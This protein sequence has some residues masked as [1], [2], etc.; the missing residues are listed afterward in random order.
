MYGKTVDLDQG[1]P[2]FLAGK[3]EQILRPATDCY[4]MVTTCISI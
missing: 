1:W 2:N 3:W 4:K